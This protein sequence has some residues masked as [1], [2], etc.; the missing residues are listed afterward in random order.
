[1]LCDGDHSILA[2]DLLSEYLLALVM[3]GNEMLTP[4]QDNDHK[5]VYYYYLILLLSLQTR[6][7]LPSLFFA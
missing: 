2:E 4:I 1:M 3:V 5:H 6:A 7:S